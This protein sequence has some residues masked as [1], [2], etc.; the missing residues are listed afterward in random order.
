MICQV[1][2]RKDFHFRLPRHPLA[3]FI[4]VGVGCLIAL[5]ND[6]SLMVPK[7][8]AGNWALMLAS[9]TRGPFLES[10]GNFSGPK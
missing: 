1:C 6:F 9:R 2:N 8:T 7:I 5:K 10:P 3:S 4:N